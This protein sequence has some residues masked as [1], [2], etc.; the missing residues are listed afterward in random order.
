[1]KK[2]IATTTISNDPE[3]TCYIDFLENHKDWTLVIAGDEQTDD[4]MYYDLVKNKNAKYL[5]CGIPLKSCSLD[6]CGQVSI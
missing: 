2:F 4:S 3:N 6:V 5:I 1:L